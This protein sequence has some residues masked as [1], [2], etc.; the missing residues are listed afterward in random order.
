MNF[1]FGQ[2]IRIGV[3]ADPMLSW[4]TP[5]SRTSQSDGSEIGID[6]GL[7]LENYFQKNY[8]LQS[9]ISIGTQGG[10]I[11]FEEDKTFDSYN[12][13]LIVSAGSTVDYKLNFITVPIGLKLKTNE[14]GYFSYFTRLGFTNQ[15]TIKS[16]ASSSDGILQDDTIENEIFFYNLFYYFGFGLQYNISKDTALLAGLNYNNGFINMSR[17]DGLKMYTRSVSLRVGIIF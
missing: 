7:I 14:I 8:A 1:T 4:L 11:L 6:G 12:E 16:K 2:S 9:G 5:E 13:E 17:E 10:S 15:F 3:F